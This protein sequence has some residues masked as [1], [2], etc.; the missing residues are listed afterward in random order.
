MQIMKALIIPLIFSQYS[1]GL[2]GPV[3]DGSGSLIPRIQTSE[4]VYKVEM[5]GS[6]SLECSVQDLGNMVLMWKQGPR[7]LT[8]GSMLVRR[9]KRLRLEGNNLVISELEEEDG[10][11]YDCEIEADG[12]MPISVTHRL[13]ILIPPRVV[14]EPADGNVV[15]KKGS[16]VSIKCVASGNPRPEVTWSKVNEVDVVGKGEI[17]HLTQVNRH[18]QGVYQCTASNGVGKTAVSQI[19]LR[20]LHKPSVTADESVVHAGV[21]HQ[22]ILACTVHSSPEA[23]VVWY[24][25]ILLLE[26]DNRMY[27]E[28]VGTRHSLV[29]HHVRE[30][31]F[32]QYRCQATNTLGTDSATVTISGKPIAPN[33][34]ERIEDMGDSSYKI[35][36]NT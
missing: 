20:V 24:R 29:L 5:G 28:V 13:D 11:E 35:M 6:V 9:D 8:A 23:E 10:G 30:E 27:R 17:M 7:V 18:H 14:S 2:S 34:E 36:W 1:F 3:L 21:G 22:A 26:P 31:E 4:K 19:N 25:G 33:I 32:T 15:V 12:D 16:S